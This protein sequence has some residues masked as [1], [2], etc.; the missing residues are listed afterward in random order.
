M[1]QEY[2]SNKVISEFSRHLNSFVPLNVLPL[3]FDLIY[4]GC[5]AWRSFQ[6]F[7][8]CWVV[9]NA[10]PKYLVGFCKP[11]TDNRQLLLVTHSKYVVSRYN[12]CLFFISLVHFSLFYQS[13]STKLSICIGGVVHPFK[14][15]GTVPSNSDQWFFFFF[16]FLKRIVIES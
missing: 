12:L 6:H 5:K 13:V 4:F 15:T 14:L 7:S 10:N 2:H 16:F 8:V 11:F 3:P 1:L 9:Q